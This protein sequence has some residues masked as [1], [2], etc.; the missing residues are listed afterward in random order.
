MGCCEGKLTVDYTDNEV[1]NQIRTTIASLN[2]TNLSVSEFEKSFTNIMRIGINEVLDTKWYNEECYMNLLSTIYI[3]NTS[4]INSNKNQMNL[5][6]KLSDKKSFP[7]FFFLQTSSLIRDSFHDKVEFIEKG[8]KGHFNPLTVKNFK[9]FIYSYLHVN[10][11]I[12]TSNYIDESNL[13]S[14]DA[15]ML[16]NKIYTEENV[17]SFST[18]YINNLNKIINKNKPFV[19]DNNEIDNE[20]IKSNELKDFFKL[21]K[22]LLDGLELRKLFYERYNNINN[23]RENL[24]EGNF[25]NKRLKINS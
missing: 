23:D 3:N 9:V 24:S 18:L 7:F 19:K 25:I 21:N 12:V 5:V 20:I 16:T 22:I 17:K 6:I 4:G 14:N 13:D 11:N 1:E 10:L 15:R 2:I 8:V